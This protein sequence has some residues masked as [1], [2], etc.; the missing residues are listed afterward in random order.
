LLYGQPGLVYVQPQVRGQSSLSSPPIND[1]RH[2][3]R[4][5]TTQILASPRSVLAGHSGQRG[6]LVIRSGP[7]LN[8]AF[9]R[10]RDAIR[11]RCRRQ[12]QLAGLFPGRSALF[13]QQICK[14]GA[15]F[16]LLFGERFQGGFKGGITGQCAG[17]C[18]AIV[19]NSGFFRRIL[20]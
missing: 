18:A 10:H 15:F 1:E 9:Y 14:L 20:R 13:S 12:A 3:L 16:G 6:F 17:I 5:S 2:K 4:T 7:A 11:A 19:Q 8:I